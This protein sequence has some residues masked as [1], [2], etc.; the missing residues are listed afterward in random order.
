MQARARF[1]RIFLCF[2]EFYSHICSFQIFF[3]PLHTK[4]QRHYDVFTSFISADMT[5]KVFLLA[6]IMLATSLSFAATTSKIG[7][8][9]YSL[10]S[11]YRTAQ[12]LKAQNE[13]TY[14]M[15]NLNIP[16]SVTDGNGWE[17]TVTSIAENAFKG[18]N[19][20]VSVIIPVTASVGNY[21]FD[22]CANLDSVVWDAA[23]GYPVTLSNGV[24]GYTPKV[25]VM[26]F[27]KDVQTIGNYLC[28]YMD[29]LEK[30]YNYALTP[31]TITVNTFHETDKSTCLLYVPLESVDLYQNAAIWQDF[32]NIIGFNPGVYVYDSIVSLTYLKANGD[33]LFMEP[34]TLS[35]PVA[36]RIPGFKFIQWQVQQGLLADGIVLEPVYEPLDP[37]DAPAVVVNPANPSQKLFKE[38]NIYILRDER[39][40]TLTG[41][42]VK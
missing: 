37:T 17:Y 11:T 4:S 6:G 35:V 39:T 5:K 3:V 31:Q 13:E 30:I 24:F 12:V 36:P 15:T 33:S 18:C 19:S 27:G 16:S 28:Y 34:K 29:K 8:L 10:N 23:N 32:S 20:L 41:Q 22:N 14:T 25:R 1:F 26:T 21:A 9:W 42:E 38:G 7:E 2:K 40:Y